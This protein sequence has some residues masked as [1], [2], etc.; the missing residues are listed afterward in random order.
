MR[1]QDEYFFL[2]MTH[3]PFNVGGGGR[4]VNFSVSPLTPRPSPLQLSQL[5]IY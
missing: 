3:G 4:S 1:E 2:S 5:E